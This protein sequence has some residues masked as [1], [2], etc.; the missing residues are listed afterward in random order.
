MPGD[1]DGDG[2]TDIAIYRPTNQTFYI[3]SSSTGTVTA[4]AIGAHADRPL[5][6]APE[7]WAKSFS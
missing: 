7:I 4:T 5:S 3:K 6:I 1:Y 2:K